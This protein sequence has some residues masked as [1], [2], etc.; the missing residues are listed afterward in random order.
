MS[1]P[2]LLANSPNP[3]AQGMAILQAALKQQQ[4]NQV[5]GGAPGNPQPLSLA[6]P[7]QG[8]MGLLSKLFG[9]GQPNPV[10]PPIGG[11]DPNTGMPPT[12]ASAAMPNLGGAG[13][14]PTAMTGLW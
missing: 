14:A 5:P 2:N 8:G 6:P 12:G 10:T 3:Q 11:I 7:S 13:P 4:G 1:I 9:G